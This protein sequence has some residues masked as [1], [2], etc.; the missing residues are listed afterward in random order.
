MPRVGEQRLCSAGIPDAHRLIIA[1]RGQALAIGRPGHAAHSTSMPTEDVWQI[2]RRRGEFGTEHASKGNNCSRHSQSDEAHS[3]TYEH[4]TSLVTSLQLL[5]RERGCLLLFP[6][7][8]AGLQKC[9]FI[10]T[11]QRVLFPLQSLF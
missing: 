8:D 1:R 10:P 9:L 7:D 4:G 2:E 6:L 11:G 5:L 3:Y